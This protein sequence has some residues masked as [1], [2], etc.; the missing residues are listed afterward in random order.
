MK[1][2]IA[3]RLSN[4]SEYWAA[5][6]P[7]QAR[8]N[9]PQIVK[10]IRSHIFLILKSTK[11]EKK[12]IQLIAMIILLVTAAKIIANVISEADKGAIIVSTSIFCIF[13][14]IIEEDE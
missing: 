12:I 6:K 3:E 8:I 1:L 11:N 9:D 13:P 2:V 4:L 10:K 5:I 7:K 14:I